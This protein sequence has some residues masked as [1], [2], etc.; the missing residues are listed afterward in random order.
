MSWGGTEAGCRGDRAVH[1][2]DRMEARTLLQESRRERTGPWDS[3]DRTPEHRHLVSKL[4][5]GSFRTSPD[6][7]INLEALENASYSYL[8][9]PEEPQ[10][11][12]G[13]V[14]RQMVCGAGRVTDIG[15]VQRS[16]PGLGSVWGHRAAQ[17]A[18][19]GPFQAPSC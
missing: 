6:S 10:V 11:G 8:P 19:P 18:A 5:C 15:E 17:R 2:V 14:L 7:V 1:R 4:C 9:A 13:P 12:Q 3:P 16:A